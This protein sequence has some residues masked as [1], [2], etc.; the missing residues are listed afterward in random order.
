MKF[1]LYIL[2]KLDISKID[3]AQ[4]LPLLE[5]IIHLSNK[6]RRQGLL[7]LEEDIEVSPYPLMRRGLQFVVDGTDPKLL[8]E[9]LERTI[10]LSNDT[11]EKIMENCIIAVGVLGIQEG[12]SPRIL[13]ENLQSFMGNIIVPEYEYTSISSRTH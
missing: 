10:L 2:S 12:Y 11:P 9:I 4:Y 8:S 13:R 5:K 1:D 6:A 3:R 7:S